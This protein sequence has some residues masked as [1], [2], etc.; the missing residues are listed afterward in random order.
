MTFLSQVVVAT[1]PFTSDRLVFVRLR[2]VLSLSTTRLMMSLALVLAIRGSRIAIVSST[3]L[4]F[5]LSI[6]MYLWQRLGT[7]RALVGVLDEEL[8]MPFCP[9][10]CLN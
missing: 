4:C 1:T 10:Q 7:H 9:K 5:L 3:L 8:I 6:S 2:S